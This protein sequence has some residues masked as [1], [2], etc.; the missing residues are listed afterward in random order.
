MQFEY[1]SNTYDWYNIDLLSHSVQKIY[2]NILKYVICTMSRKKQF[3]SVVKTF[4][5]LRA[6]QVSEANLRSKQEGINFTPFDLSLPFAKKKKISLMDGGPLKNVCLSSVC[7]LSVVC[8]SSV[9]RLS[10]VTTFTLNIF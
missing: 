1:M 6:E 2:N 7:C 10:V 3:W 8:L 4:I 5:P 9:S